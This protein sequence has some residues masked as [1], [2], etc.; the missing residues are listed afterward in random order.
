MSAAVEHLYCVTSAGWVHFHGNEA[1]DVSAWP[2]LA[3]SAL[4]VLD[5]DEIFTDS[6]RFEGKAE[7]AIPLIEKRARTQ[8]LVE[9]ATH[10]VVHRLTKVPGGFQAYFSAIPL[11]LWQRYAAWARE[12]NEHCLIMTATGLLCHGIRA[13]AARVLLSHRRLMFFAQVDGGMFFGSIQILGAGEDGIG[14]AAQALLGRQRD[15]WSRIEA[16]AVEYGVLWGAAGGN[17]ALL[18][19]LQKAL[20]GAPRALPMAELVFRNAPLQTALPLLARASATHHALNPWIQRIAWHAERWVRPV[21]V[22]TALAGL[23]LVF[24]GVAV[25]L[26][27]DKQRATGDKQRAEL[28]AL[29]TRIQA[30]ATVTPPRELLPVAAFV[31]QLDE[32]VQYDPMLLLADL[33]KTAGR[34]LQ[35][36]HVRLERLPQTQGRSFRVDG[37]ATSNASA[38]IIHWAGQMTAA[39][40]TLKALDPV[41]AIP[42][43]FSYQLIKTAQ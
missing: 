28:E 21:T 3:H 16:S 38:A 27:V 6:W 29:Q 8:G 19:A 22:V 4:V 26:Q 34:E 30:V 43:A 40:W 13:G 1:Q 12:Q 18:S 31:H 23:L 33:K 10:V 42:G 9:G 14:S 11:E 37:I 41:A 35:I 25:M 36:Q 39:G 5:L 17:E 24:V 32:G 15:L 7:H 20:G 2:S